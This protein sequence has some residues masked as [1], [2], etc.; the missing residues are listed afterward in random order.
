MASQSSEKSAKSETKTKHSRGHALLEKRFV[1]EW[2]RPDL[3]VLVAAVIA[4]LL[5]GAGCYSAW[6]AETPNE[7]QSFLLLGGIAVLGFFVF[8]ISSGREVVFVGDAG[9]AVEQ[10]GELTR[11]LWF[12]IESIRY[13]GSHLVL[14]GA[15]TTL[16]LPS[17]CHT[18]AIRAI[19]AETASR[20]P[21]I[22]D[23]PAKLVDQL[24]KVVGEDPSPR[25]ITSLQV[26]GKRCQVTNQ[27]L[28]FERDARLCPVCT[29]IYHR[30]HVPAKCANCEQPL[31]SAAVAVE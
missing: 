11:L 2:N 16:R 31:G 22:L 24:P 13:Q 6:I 29:S 28:T 20:L 17:Q 14:T 26:A 21:K 19:L 5:L 1:S 10:G 15:N 8:R 27:V 12:E 25:P 9:V 3:G 30:D 7:Y 23:V 4:G 18:R